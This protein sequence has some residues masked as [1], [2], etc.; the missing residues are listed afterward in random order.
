MIPVKEF[1]KSEIW[2]LE[3]GIWNLKSDLAVR[4]D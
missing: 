2:N 3:S 1:R 4:E